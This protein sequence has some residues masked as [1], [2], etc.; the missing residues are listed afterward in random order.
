VLRRAALLVGVLGLLSGA[1]LA[2]LAQ[3]TTSQATFDPRP[4]AILAPVSRQAGW[5]SLEAPRPR[6]LTR[7]VPPSYVADLAVSSRRDAVIAVQSVNPG[8]DAIGGDLLRLNLD[9][10]ETTPLATRADADESLGAPAWLPDGSSLVYQR[11]DVRSAPVSYIGQAAVRYPSRIEMVQADG[12]NRSVVVDDGRQPALSPNGAQIAY[13]RSSRAGTALLIR[14][15]AATA[16]DEHELVPAGR[17]PDVAYPRFA[18]YGDQIA[19]AAV[20]S[21]AGRENLF[22]TLFGS[23]VAYAHGLPWDIWLVGS[24]GTG[25]H[26]LAAVGADDPSVTWSADGTQIFVYGGAGSFIVDTATGEAVNYS[27]VAGY[28]ATAWLP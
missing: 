3:S 28:G 5:L 15:Q 25:L 9:S 14:A 17:F 22:E 12:T 19:F 18:P 20:V 7:F 13:V 1:P 16:A 26:Q 10:G 2:S 6:L 4:G 23:A 21:L 27:F 24:D 8:Q 11:D